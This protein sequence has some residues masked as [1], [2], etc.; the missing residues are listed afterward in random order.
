[1]RRLQVEALGEFAARALSRRSRGEVIAVFRR[2]FY[3]ALGDAILCVGPPAFADGPLNLLAALDALG[4]TSLPDVGTP[5]QGRS[6]ALLVGDVTFR[7]EGLT[8]WRPPAPPPPERRAPAS[9]LRRL[10]RLLERRTPPALGAL[11]KPLAAGLET[12]GALASPGF[13]P[14]TPATVAALRDW[15]RGE[16]PEPPRC[17]RL[18]GLGP[19]LTPSGDDFLCGFMLALRRLGRGDL[20][21]RVWSSAAGRLE[22]TNPISAAFL[23]AAWAGSAAA[24]I[25]AICDALTA[26]AS[27]LEARLPALDAIGHSSGWDCLAGLTAAAAALAD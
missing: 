25:I 20:A 26:Q 10:S 19:G 15:A 27:E 21:D 8:G 23:E 14:D 2:S 5:A 22:T 18:V 7:V 12:L 6:D 9:G 24:P 4:E 13:L 11:A 3:V 16:R 17:E 1:M